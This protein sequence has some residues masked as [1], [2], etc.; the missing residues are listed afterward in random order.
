MSPVRGGLKE[1]KD[2]NANEKKSSVSRGYTK[3][4][5]EHFYVNATFALFYIGH[6]DHRSCRL[7]VHV[8]EDL[9]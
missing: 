4:N 2:Q 8:T 5:E 7:N 1:E 6:L 3:L 9:F